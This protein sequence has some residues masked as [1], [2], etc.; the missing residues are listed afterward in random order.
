MSVYFEKERGWKYDFTLKRERHLSGYFQTKTKAKQAEAKRKE[1]L[2]NPTR[3]TQTDMAFLDLVNLRLDHVK[4][5]NSIRHYQDYFYMAKRWVE[6][7][8]RLRCSQIRH[9]MIRDFILDRNGVSSNTANKEIR[10]LRATFN[11]GKKRRY[12]SNN[13]IDGIEFLPVEKKIKYV[14]PADD[15]NRVIKLADSRNPRLSVG[16]KGNHGADERN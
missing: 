12:L 14:P 9:D 5:Y 10:Y 13:P 16:Y 4:V 1:D 6:R 8:A 2:L 7:W 3:M 15:I 11:F